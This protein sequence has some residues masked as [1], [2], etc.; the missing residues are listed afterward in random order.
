MRYDTQGLI[1]RHDGKKGMQWGVRLYQYPDGRWTPLGK[2]RY[3]KGDVSSI[4]DEMLEASAKRLEKEAAYNKRIADLNKATDEASGGGKSSKD[5]S[6]LPR[7]LNNRRDYNAAVKAEASV[8]TSKELKDAIE[9]KRLEDEYYD[10]YSAK[11]STLSKAIKQG[12]QNAI[13]NAISTQVNRLTNDV[14]GTGVDFIEGATGLAGRKINSLQASWRQEVDKEVFKDSYRKSLKDGDQ[15]DAN[16]SSGKD[17]S[18]Q[19][20]STKKAEATV[21]ANG[22]SDAN[23]AQKK[24]GLFGKNK[25]DNANTTKQGSTEADGWNS[26]KA[27]KEAKTKQLADI[28]R[29]L[30][31]KN[32]TFSNQQMLK[33]TRSVLNG[34]ASKDEI[35]IFNKALGKMTNALAD[36]AVSGNGAKTAA[37]N[38]LI[39]K[40]SSNPS[41]S[42][43]EY[44]Q[45]FMQ[46]F[47]GL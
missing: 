16:G 42:L 23:S 31:D 17:S 41:D 15:S 24:G 18:G 30:N 27:E 46:Y 12:V 8:M 26:R 22:S 34:K 33:I 7:G 39:K 4:P 36:D 2:R 9:R 1:I 29:G 40:W 38:A 5:F 25:G 21:T 35:N 28:E 6:A 32:N 14:L 11:E 10:K 45:A 37:V 20:A 19:S 44:G 47:Q 3:G 13:S 43:D